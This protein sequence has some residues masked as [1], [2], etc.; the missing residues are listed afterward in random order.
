MEKIKPKL[1]IA[2]Q[3]YKECAENG[4]LCYFGSDGM[5]TLVGIVSASEESLDKV[6]SSLEKKAAEIGA[7]HVFGVD[8]L[9]SIAGNPHSI[10]TMYLAFGDAYKSGK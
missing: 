8:Y 4:D 6:N 9:I 10:R 5:L 2:K 7:T 1:K 3:T